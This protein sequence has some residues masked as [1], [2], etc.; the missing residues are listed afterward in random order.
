MSNIT[1]KTI[2][3]AAIF[4]CAHAVNAIAIK[5]I[6][7]KHDLEVCV[8]S[9]LNQAPDSTLSIYGNFENLRS[10][11]HAMTLYLSSGTQQRDANTAR[12][13]IGIL[14]LARKVFKHTDMLDEIS[15]RLNQV[16]EQVELFG[17]THDNVLANLASIYTD[18]ISTLRPKIMV[19]GEHS[20]LSN[21][22]NAAK[23]RTLLLAGVR[24]GILWQQVK[25]SRWQILWKRQSFVDEAR[26]ILEY[27]MSSHLH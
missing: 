23:V 24:A 5:G 27:E 9:I 19:S 25:G 13:V 16:R 12:Y 20:Y 1:D 14:H 3:L 6:V 26:R 11:L 8:R 4:Q 17:I 2:A 7:D 18:T 21:P 10:G 15:S 22:A